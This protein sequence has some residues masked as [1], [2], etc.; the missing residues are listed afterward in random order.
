MADKP[1]LNQ[2][3]K[4]I[5]QLPP[6]EQMKLV[7][8]VGERL[9]KLSLTE[10][11]ERPDLTELQK[12]EAEWISRELEDFIRLIQQY[13]AL[14]LTAIFIAVGWALGQSAS[15]PKQDTIE[16]FRARPDVAAILCII[17][18]L[19]VFIIAILLEAY[20]HLKSLARYRFVLGFTLGGGEPAWRWERW[21]E[22]PEGSVQSWTGTLNGFSLLLLMLLTVGALWFPIP[23]VWGSRTWVL[24]ALWLFGVL[25]VAGLVLLV[26]VVGYRNRGRNA[27]AD[28]PSTRWH[29]LWPSGDDGTEKSIPVAPEVVKSPTLPENAPTQVRT[30]DQTPARNKTKP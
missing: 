26:I 19:N 9:S 14:Y 7:A 25:S 1:D 21:R 3:E 6:R 12:M 8:Q 4:A 22:T 28:P 30:A 23:A 13:R 15:A 27:V 17:P 16:S 18:L 2:I 29:D 10:G 11:A 24:P 20:H 5:G